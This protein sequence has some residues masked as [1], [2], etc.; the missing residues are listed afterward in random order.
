MIIPNIFVFISRLKMLNSFPFKNMTR[1][2][3]DTKIKQIQTDW[4][5]E[6]QNVSKFVA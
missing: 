2:Q 5:G 6:H 4:G 3:F 1:T